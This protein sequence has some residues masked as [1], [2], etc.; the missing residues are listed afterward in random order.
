MQ[1]V[2]YVS[3]ANIISDDLIL[4][5]G[6]RHLGLLGGAGTYAA[7]GMR[8][9]SDA[10]GIVSGVGA[11]FDALFGG[12]FRQNGIDTQ[13][14][15]VR[16]AQTPHSTMNYASADERVE[17]PQFGPEHFKRMEPTL[18]D[19][20]RAYHA[21]RALYLFRDADPGYWDLVTT[22]Q[23]Q[24]PRPPVVVW[25]LHT[26]AADARQ[27]DAAAAI[28]ARIDLVSLNLAEA[29]ALC[30]LAKP[31]AIVRKLLAAGVGAVVLRLGA[32]GTLVADQHRTWHIPI[33]P[34]EVQDVT[35]AGNA[36]TGGFLVGYC[37]S[38]GDVRRAG[39]CGA[40]A[41]SFM[42][43]QFGPPCC[44]DAALEA[45]ARRRADSLTPTPID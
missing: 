6:T 33:Y 26:G 24:A 45:D 28:L 32:E 15:D 10:V 2:Q 20:P 17:T 30:A 37:M 8:L 13:G 43:E 38:G 22:F 40:A 25:E 41:A 27:W 34:V 31:R 29:R 12:W 9:W 11:D 21:T 5:D 1:P 23:A 18:A 4:P 16:A 44:I 42:L 39:C 36:F 7:A 3:V 35:G 19:L 14:L